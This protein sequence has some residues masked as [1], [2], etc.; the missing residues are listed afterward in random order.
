MTAVAAHPSEP[1]WR[2]YVLFRGN[3]FAVFWREHGRESHRR[4]LFVTGC[5]FDP[6][7]TLGLEKLI[8]LTGSTPSRVWVLR[9]DE[10]E[11][12]PPESQV[13]AVIDN[14]ARLAALAG[15]EQ[16]L[17]KN[18]RFW[19]EDGRRIAARSAANAVLQY[20]DISEYSDIV[21][22]ISAMPQ[23]VFFP[24]VARLLYFHDTLRKQGQPAPNIHVLV[25][26]DPKFD[27]QVREHGIDETAAYM[28]PFEGDFNREATGISPRIWIPVLG[29]GRT[30]QFDRIYDLV[31]PDEVSPVLP[32]PARDP[33]HGDNI[34]LE[35]RD[36]LFDQLRIDPKNF[37]YASEFNPF[38]VY[39]QIR[40]ATTH[41]H[42]VLK[43][44][45]GCKVAVS[46]LCS[47]VMA[48][49]VLLVAYDMKTSGVLNV[50]VAH[51]ES[52]GYELPAQVQ[53]Q[54]G[55]VGIWL[56]GECYE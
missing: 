46:A 15:S 45:G 26:E 30:T 12:S 33:R 16:L 28:H 11:I 51:I 36:L 20:A 24:L 52:Q 18:I 35:Y 14:W 6:R 19:S 49:G 47:K 21:V 32:S 29:E 44:I 4:I 55:Q 39:R 48:L 10:G 22:D 9:Y 56:A 27:S 34:V 2:D 8:D 31:K 5:G 43:L 38:E 54:V 17:P 50:G 37:I 41:Y 7:T 3:E 42:D 40:Q 23:G 1:R 25:S 13:K 53:L